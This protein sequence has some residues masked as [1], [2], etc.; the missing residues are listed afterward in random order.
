MY[1]LLI[2]LIVQIGEDNIAMHASVRDPTTDPEEGRE[3]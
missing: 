1:S 2:L 3:C